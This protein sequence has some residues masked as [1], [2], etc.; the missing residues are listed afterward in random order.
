MYFDFCKPSEDEAVSCNN[1]DRDCGSAVG[2]AILSVTVANSDNF[3]LQRVISWLNPEATAD[4]GSFQVMQGLYAIGSG[5][6]FGKGLGNS[7]QKLGVIPE[8]QNDMILVVI[9]EELGVFGAVV[10]LVLFALL[11]YRL[12][13]IAKNAPDLFGSLIATGIFA[14]IAL[15]VI[16]NIA[17]VTGLLPTTGITLPFISYGGTANRIFDGGNGN[18]A[19]NFTE[20]KIRIEKA[21]FL[22]RCVIYLYVVLKT[23]YNRSVKYILRF[24]RKCYG[25]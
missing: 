16:L 10:I 9:C 2:I 11:L 1:R 18:C 5:G 15:Q 4:T 22:M 20:N 6:L 12:I 7:T 25:L 19:W 17:V 14:H 3:R 13:F 24:R 23:T 21:S 8:A